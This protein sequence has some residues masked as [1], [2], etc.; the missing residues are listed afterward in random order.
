[1]Q[2]ALADWM[3]LLLAVLTCYRLAQFVTLDD[4][5][6]YVCRDLRRQLNAIAATDGKI[7]KSIA[8]LFSCPYCMGVWF[9]IPCALAYLYPSM[10]TDVILLIVGIAGAQAFLQGRNDGE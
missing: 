6:M 9:A 8:E 3:R 5:P 4:G 1:M 10:L 2:N 7:Q